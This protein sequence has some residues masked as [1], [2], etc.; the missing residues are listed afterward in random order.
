MCGRYASTRNPATLAVEFDAVDATDGAAPGAVYNIAP[1]APV[2]SVV[3]RHPRDPQG[4]PHQDRTVRSIRVMRWGLVPHWAKDAGAGSRL[5]NARAESAASKPAFRDAVARRRCLLPADGWYEWQHKQ[6]FFITPAER[7]GLAMAGLWS[8]WRPP[9]AT[10]PP[11]VTCAVLTTSAVGPLA[12]IHDRMPLILPAQAWEA[13]LD[14][15]SDDP[16]ELLA[17]PSAQLVHAL[18]LRP[19]STAVNN[20][21]R[22]GPELVERVEPEQPA[23]LSSDGGTVDPAWDQLR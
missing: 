13:W 10:A 19:V 7:S 21:R 23:L 14:P 9:D 8:T 17:P 1:T 4:V 11:L 16:G 2:L 20:V 12:E 18:E 22:D 15:G 6:P 5:I 3:T